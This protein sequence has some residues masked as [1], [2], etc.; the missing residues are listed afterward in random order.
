MEEGKK[1]VLIIAYYWPPAGGPG[2]QRW[3]KFAK[4]LPENGWRP[5]LLVPEGASYPLIDETLAREIPE[6]LEVIRVPI[7][8]PYETAIKLF[9]GK[10]KAER[11]GSV[12]QS[13][14]PSLKR[15]LMM[16]CRGNLLVPD[17]RVFWRRKAR[18]AALDV[19]QSAVQKG[20]PYHAVVTTGPPHSVHLIGLDIKRKLGLPWLSDFRDLWREMDYLEDFHP[21]ART[22]R[23]HA[24]MEKAVIEASDRV[25]FPTAGVGA[26]LASID[27]QPTENKMHLIHNGW[28][29]ADLPQHQIAPKSDRASK[30]YQL[31]HFGSLIPVRDAPGLWEAIRLWNDD[32]ASHRKPIHLNLVGSVNPV[33]SESIQKH[34]RPEEWTNHG[35]V[36]HEKAIEMMM[37]MDA[38]LLLQNNN[39]TGARAIPGKA[40]EY[41]ATGRPM[42]V[43]TPIP[44]D[45]DEIAR[46]WELMPTRHDDVQGASQML[47]SLW[48]EGVRKREHIDRF[49]R[50]TLTKRMAHA[51]NTLIPNQ[52]R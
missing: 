25:T 11:L 37:D 23:T 29:P 7:F 38:L 40:F 42:A 6:D 41:L 43:V 35:Y 48:T 19:L 46:E 47:E 13:N 39:D 1:R 20:D 4:Y 49:S 18:K 34:L 9:Q 8:E 22:R 12:A 31:G 30:S 32:S 52:T 26:S 17:P 16:W 2:V 51:L 33:V 5:S 45:M 15:F 24:A 27:S 3:L 21:T 50:R 44:S 36:S 10:N 28:D 14:R